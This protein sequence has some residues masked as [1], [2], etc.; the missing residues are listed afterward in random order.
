M[1]SEISGHLQTIQDTYQI[2]F[3]LRLRYEGAYSAL[4]T[5]AG[6]KVREGKGRR[7]G[8]GG[9][10]RGREDDLFSVTFLGPAGSRVTTDCYYAQ[11]L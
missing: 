4:Q 3:R 5:L 1:G 2:R 11:F 7:G 6:F 8:K 10:W 9:E